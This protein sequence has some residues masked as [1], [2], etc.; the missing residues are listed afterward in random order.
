MALGGVAGQ[1]LGSFYNSAETGAWA[2]AALGAAAALFS[3]TWRGDRLM[4]WLR[5]DVA[6]TAPRDSGRWGEMAYRIERA[7]RSR[8]LAIDM[9]RRQNG[10]FLSGIEASP[11]GVLLLD[12]ND[13][14]TWCNSVAADHFG[15]DPVRDLRQRI[16]NLVR[17]PNFVAYLQTGDF[18]DSIQI[19]GGSDKRPLNVLVRPYGDDLKLILSQ[20]MT[21][22][23]QTQSMQRDFVA[24]VSHEIR[25]PITVLAG[26]IETMARLPLSEQERSHVLGLMAQQASRMQLLVADLLTLAQL[27]GSPRPASDQWLPVADL[28]HRA[29]ADAL[30]LS[31]GRHD[32]NCKAP[33][34]AELAGNDQELLSAIGNLLT[35]AIRYTP[36]GGR[37]DVI[38]T[39]RD[40]GGAQITVTD[41]GPGIAREHLARL[42]ER[43]YRVDDSRSRDTGGTGLGLSIVKH[44]M[45][46]HGGEVTVVSELGLGAQFCLSF[47]AMR[48]RRRGTQEPMT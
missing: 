46:R 47:P 14:I 3:D 23:E 44:V 4:L 21:E 25:T 26:F 29:H 42:T 45:L 5:G 43:F 33:D 22:R 27:E 35:N 2:G 19:A 37:I 10:Q 15:L 18:N 8:D 31:V 20:D 36:V 9:E 34:D 1:I 16:T 39:W 40:Q 24:N 12:A 6:T 28:M 30:A 41:N 11:N 13:Q 32:I 7:L 38:W 17:S 48:A